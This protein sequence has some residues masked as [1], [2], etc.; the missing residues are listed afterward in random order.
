MSDNRI[1]L[2]AALE[3]LPE[4]DAHNDRSTPASTPAVKVFLPVGSATWFLT[5]KDS[6]EPDEIRYFGL[7]DL[8]LGFPELGWVDREGLL[9][10]EV[11]G[12]G[13]EL[14]EYTQN[15]TLGTGY[16][17]CGLEVPSWMPA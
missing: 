13:V 7:C 2:I 16:L 6:S 9:G 5:D 12:L 3:A 14:D 4:W 15:V 11:M 10:I 8:G 17:Y 1:K